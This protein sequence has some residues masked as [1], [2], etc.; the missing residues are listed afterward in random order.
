M[1]VI[2]FDLIFERYRWESETEGFPL[3]LMVRYI[4]QSYIVVF[5]EI[6]ELPATVYQNNFVNSIKP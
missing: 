5:I 1:T 4:A 2:Y 6:L 3:L